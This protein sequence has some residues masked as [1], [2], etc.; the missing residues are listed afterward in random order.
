MSAWGPGAWENDTAADWLG[1]VIERAALA[2]EI[3]QILKLDLQDNHELIRAAASL[4][5][6]LGQ[7]FIW[8]SEHRD[9]QRKLAAS[10]LRLMLERNILQDEATRDLAREELEKLAPGGA[11]PSFL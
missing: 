7:P 8:P 2:K 11:P 3:D 4:L 5:H 10:K 6:V 1:E 9:R